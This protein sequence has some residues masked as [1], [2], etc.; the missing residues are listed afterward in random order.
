[1]HPSSSDTV[2]AARS[3][4]RRKPRIDGSGKDYEAVMRSGRTAEYQRGVG[5][6]KTEGIRE[7]IGHLAGLG[8]PWHQIDIARRRRVVEVERRGN[9]PM[10]DRKYREDCLDAAGCAE[11]MPNR[12]FRRRH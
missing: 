2:T 8:L 11:Q 12:R 9:D 4:R 1:M 5:A 6:P 3:R 10:A 7:R